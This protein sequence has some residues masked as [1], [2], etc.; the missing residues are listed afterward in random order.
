MTWLS[1]HASLISFSSK[2]R[3]D[4][5]PLC[6]DCSEVTSW[7]KRHAW[8]N[9]SSTRGSSSPDV[10]DS[11]VRFHTAA[12]EF[13]VRVFEVF[14]CD[15]GLPVLSC[16]NIVVKTKRCSS[17]ITVL[18]RVF[19]KGGSVNT[20]FTL[21]QDCACVHDCW[22]PVRPVLDGFISADESH[23]GVDHN[24]ISGTKLLSSWW[25][26]GTFRINHLTV[27]AGGRLLV[28]TA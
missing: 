8:F 18:S 24:L 28:K 17:Y 1:F 10:I 14:P 6:S 25:S 5:C 26:S 15:D 23:L 7:L 3:T 4:M 12:P 19:P 22:P 20:H 27:N 9:F 11:T 16:L 2:S 21:D 13:V